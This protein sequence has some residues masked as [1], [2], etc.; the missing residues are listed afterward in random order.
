[1]RELLWMN[2]EI[3]RDEAFSKY[4]SETLI[5]FPRWVM[6][7]HSRESKCVV[8]STSKIES[9]VEIYKYELKY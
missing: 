2:H 1:M 9:A 6:H 5:L 7:L 4:S 3:K 8:S